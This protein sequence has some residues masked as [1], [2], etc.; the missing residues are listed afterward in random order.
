M[1]RQS[2]TGR[3]APERETQVAP[4]GM[5][6]VGIIMDGN[7]RWASRRGRPRTAGHLAGARTVQRIVES[8]TALGIDVL[9]LYAFSSD[10]WRR[11]PDEVD[12]LMRVFT[13]YLSTHV[14]RC[15]ANDI[16]LRIIGRRDRLDVTL[17]AAIERAER[18]TAAGTRMLLRIAL[19]YSA[20][21][22]IVR[23][24]ERFAAQ[25]GAE[26][27]PRI[28]FARALAEVGTSST[29][30][31]GE[32]A[33]DVDLL[34]RTGGEQ[35]LSDFLLWESAYAELVFSP[36]MWPEFTSADLRDALSEFRRRDRRFGVLPDSAAR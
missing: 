7:G 33:P 26:D 9:T 23:A 4:D 28:A 25:R 30:E 8:A 11:P 36:R 22:Q 13:R 16:R 20:R 19:D 10:N 17:R 14:T 5:L 1:M 6:H 24:A 34:V 2:I 21:D 35:R 29:A 3:S 18:E 32:S 27:D 15:V 31:L 12:A